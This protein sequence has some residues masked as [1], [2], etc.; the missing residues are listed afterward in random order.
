[1]HFA[2][3]HPQFRRMGSARRSADPVRSRCDLLDRGPGEWERPGEPPLPLDAARIL[4]W[5]CI[6]VEILR[7]VVAAGR[8]DICVDK[9]RSSAMVPR[10]GSLYRLRDRDPLVQPGAGLE[11]AERLDLLRVSRR[12]PRRTSRYYPAF[13]AGQHSG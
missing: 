9:P 10:A 1:Q 6:A 11:L 13:A 2:P 7:R 5:T 8:S 3:V 12:A 4:A